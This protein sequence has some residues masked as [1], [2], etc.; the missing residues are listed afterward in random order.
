MLQALSKMLTIPICLC[1]I[2]MRI[3]VVP[4]QLHSMPDYSSILVALESEGGVSYAQRLMAQRG[5]ADLIGEREAWSPESLLPGTSILSMPHTGTVPLVS[6][7]PQLTTLCSDPIPAIS[8]SGVS[9]DTSFLFASRLA[10]H[11]M[12]RQHHSPPTTDT[13]AL[14]AITPKETAQTP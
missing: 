5:P 9:T 2:Y 7:R 4:R 10:E 11:Y 6:S 8:F 1:P 12:D 3:T 14:E 13:P